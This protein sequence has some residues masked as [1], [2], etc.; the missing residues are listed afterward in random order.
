MRCR[1]TTNDLY[2]ANI[3]VV[4]AGIC[5]KQLTQCPRLGLCTSTIVVFGNASTDALQYSSLSLSCDTNVAALGPYYSVYDVIAIVSFLHVVSIAPAVQSVNQ[6]ADLF[7]VAFWT[8][9]GARSGTLIPG[10][11]PQLIHSQRKT[12]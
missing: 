4:L 7:G 6:N 10:S 2:D 11:Y 3:D 8:Q 12:L 5:T 9:I 1:F